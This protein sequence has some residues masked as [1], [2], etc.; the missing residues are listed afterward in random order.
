MHTTRNNKIN[1]K[2]HA[3]TKTVRDS[4]QQKQPPRQYLNFKKFTQRQH[5]HE[6]NNA[7]TLLS[8]NLSI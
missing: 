2:K 6:E 3:L 8:P 1:G 4:Q 7:Q 5:I